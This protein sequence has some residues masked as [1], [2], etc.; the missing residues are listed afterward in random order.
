MAA[1]QLVEGTGVEVGARGH[2]VEDGGELALVAADVE[3]LRESSGCAHGRLSWLGYCTGAPRIR[4]LDATT[5]RAL[6]A[7]NRRFYRERAAEFSATREEPWPGWRRLWPRLAAGGLPQEPALL[8]VGCGNGRFGRFAA[9]RA[10]GLRYV[11][12]DASEELLAF[13]RAQD[14]LGAEPELRRIDLVEDD[15]APALAGR[16]FWLVAIFGVLHHVPGR[17]RRRALLAEVLARVDAGG[18]L[19]LT[20]WQLAAFARFRGRVVPWVQRGADVAPGLDL[21]QLE[22][23]DHLLRWGDGTG[24][25]Y[26]HF[27]DEEETARLLAELPCEVVESFA[28]DGRSGD[29]NRYYAVRRRA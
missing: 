20:S 26:V 3:A 25:R 1:H 12:L 18:W 21:S 10:P 14:A 9:E 4:A 28:A 16:R 19:A 8:D 22:A 2:G 7:I 24:V 27:A 15:L 11:G 5:A 17:E 6:N 29:L 23:G 13:A